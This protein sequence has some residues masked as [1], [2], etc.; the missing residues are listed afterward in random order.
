M[1]TSQVLRALEKRGLVTRTPDHADT[2][3]G[4]PGTSVAAQATPVPGPA[5]GDSQPAC[6]RAMPGSSARR[7][8]GP[9]LRDPTAIAAPE[10]V[11]RRSVTNALAIPPAPGTPHRTGLPATS[12]SLHWPVPESA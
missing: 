3:V 8:A 7:P 12:S 9:R 1:M 11:S 4:A 10:S 2:R 5:A 6:R